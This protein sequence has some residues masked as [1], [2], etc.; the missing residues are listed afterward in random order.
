MRGSGLMG[1]AFGVYLG[2]KRFG[3]GVE[4]WGTSDKTIQKTPNKL[5]ALSP[6]HHSTVLAETLNPEPQIT[7]SLHCSSFFRF[8]QFYIQD[9]KR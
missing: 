3:L 6:W 7:Y 8:N 1:S 4:V 2:L 9:P 5:S